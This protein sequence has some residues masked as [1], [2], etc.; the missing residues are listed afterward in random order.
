MNK[1]NMQYLIVSVHTKYVIAS[2][3]MTTSHLSTALKF[4]LGLALCFAIRLIPGRPPNVEP[5]MATLLPF[6][7]RM[8]P[9]AGFLFGVLSMVLFDAV[10]GELGTWT[11]VT[12]LTF[13]VIGAGSHI[14]LAQLPGSALP[15]AFVAAVATIFYD[16]VTG[17]LMGN[18]LFDMPLAQ[19]F[20]GQIPFTANHLLSNIILAFVFSP[21]IERWI[22]ANP[23]L[24]RSAVLHSA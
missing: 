19:A 3:P 4:L 1:H 22:V 24:E 13:G 23:R 9:F 5:V 15:Y 2:P 10:T 12:G 11:L 6:G 17:V 8:G 7:K 20:L 14:A 18:L 16:L 21:L